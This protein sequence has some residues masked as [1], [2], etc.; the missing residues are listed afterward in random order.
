[1]GREIVRE[2]SPSDLGKRSRLWCAKESIDVLTEKTGTETIEGLTLN[3]TDED[4]PAK[5]FFTVKNSK[6]RNSG[7]FAEKWKL[8]DGNDAVKRH[9]LSLFS[10]LPINHA[11]SESSSTLSDQLGTILEG[12]QGTRV[13]KNPQSQPFTEAYH[14]T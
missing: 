8:V 14:Y 12:N 13:F 3:W 9:R 10:W 7:D 5:S 2:E 6:R 4:K 11:L 1:M